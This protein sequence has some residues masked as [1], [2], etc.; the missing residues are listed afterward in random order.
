MSTQ[1]YS[2]TPHPVETL[3]TWVK[4]GEIA[5][6]EIQRPFVWEATKVRNLLDSLYQGYPVGYLIAWRNPSV[7]LKDGSTSIGKRILIDGQQRVTA[8]MA[9]LLGVEVLTDDYET[10]RIRIAFNPQEERFEVAN[11]AIRKNV[12]WIPD[13]ATVFEPTTSLF[14]LVSDYCAAN[15]AS[16]QDQIFKVI[17][18]LRGIINNHVGIIDLAEDLDIETVTEIF[19]RVNS[20]GSPLSQADFAMSK[21]A[22]NTSYG[23]N[24]LRKAIDYFCHLAIAPEF[25]AKIKKGDKAF[26]GSEFFSK[27][28]WIA[29]VNDDIYDPT[30]TD[31]LRVAF[32]SEFGRGK[33]QDL[34]ALL[35]G[36][37]FETKQY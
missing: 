18:K 25:L 30:Y 11:P 20:A 32:T 33:L 7:R 28:K 35:S 4:S 3:L 26:V 2:V 37:N 14:Q 6:P 31:M 8:L 22:V 36:R 24:M 27:M 17:E 21:I 10:V 16:S 1:R 9:S 19:I 15:P 34:V 13:V 29:D 5:I 12:A 23:G